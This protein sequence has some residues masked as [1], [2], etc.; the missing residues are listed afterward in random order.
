MSSNI[1]VLVNM[2]RVQILTLTYYVYANGHKFFILSFYWFSIYHFSCIYVCGLMKNTH[3]IYI[4]MKGNTISTS[5]LNYRLK[6][7]RL[8][9]TNIF[10]SKAM[11]KA[12]RVFENITENLISK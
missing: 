3:M 11:L 1:E 7:N 5:T 2:S 10:L 8:K 4:N 12:N 9:K 6:S